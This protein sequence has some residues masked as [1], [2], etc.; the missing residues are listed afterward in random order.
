MFRQKCRFRLLA[1]NTKKQF[2]VKNDQFFG[3]CWRFID[4]F[5]AFEKLG[6]TKTGLKRPKTIWLECNGDKWMRRRAGWMN[7]AWFKVTNRKLKWHSETWRRNEKISHFE[8]RPLR[9]KQFRFVISGFTS[10]NSWLFPWL[11]WNWDFS[12]F[13]LCLRRLGRNFIRNFS[14]PKTGKW[15]KKT[16]SRKTWHKEKLAAIYYLLLLISR[17][18]AG[19]W[20]TFQ[21]EIV[22]GMFVDSRMFQMQKRRKF[23]R[24]AHT[25]RAFLS[26]LKKIKEVLNFYRYFSFTIK[27]NAS[28]VFFVKI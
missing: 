19:I 20:R 14:F 1:E 7:V 3:F 17:N 28:Q 18:K 15:D 21:V 16:T 8:L 25:G 22:D 9:K 4:F 13:S 11:F 5:F 10:D 26:N 6:G 2:R 27:N 23:R 24:S 12:P